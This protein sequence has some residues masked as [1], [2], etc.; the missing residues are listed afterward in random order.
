[1]G[2]TVE[3]SPQPL[4]TN[5]VYAVWIDINNLPMNDPAAPNDVFS[6]YIQKEGDANRT[7]LFKDYLSNLDLTA[8]DPVLGGASPDLD[9]LFVGGNNTADSALFDDFYLS[10]SGFNT[11]LP[12]VY[13]F[14][15]PLGGAPTQGASLRAAPQ[16]EIS[17]TEGTLESSTSLPGNWST[18]TGAAPPSYKTSPDGTQRYFRVRQ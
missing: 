8:V 3:F 14:T 1:V 13:G 12:R 15:A 5:V 2:G 18:V 9:K 6:V 16:V 17:W 11:T 7:E 4:Q 10:K